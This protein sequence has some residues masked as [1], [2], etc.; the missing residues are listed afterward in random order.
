LAPLRYLPPGDG[1]ADRGKTQK[2]KFAKFEISKIANRK[3]QNLENFHH[4][5]F[6]K[7]DREIVFP[8]DRV[9][10]LTIG[11]K[12]IASSLFVLPLCVRCILNAS[13]QCPYEATT[14]TRLNSHGS[15]ER[16]QED[17]M[18]PLRRS[19]RARRDMS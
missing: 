12:T 5:F 2:S 7:I 17:T 18:N 4:N 1:R 9:L 13:K 14:S 10:V 6:R 8:Q 11:C 3:K 16:T 19:Q 15:E